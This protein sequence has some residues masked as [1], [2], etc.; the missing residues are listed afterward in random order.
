MQTRANSSETNIYFSVQQLQ[1]QLI[2]IYLINKMFLFISKDDTIQPSASFQQTTRTRNIN[3]LYYYCSKIA[4]VP[5]YD[6]LDHVKDQY[7]NMI[8]QNDILTDIY[9]ILMI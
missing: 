8:I 7:N 1:Q 5:K 2:L 9:Y 4:Q 6:N 3:E